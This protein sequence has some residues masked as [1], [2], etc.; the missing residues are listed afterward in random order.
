MVVLSM[1]TNCCRNMRRIVDP[2]EL[3]EALNEPSVLAACAPGF[4]HI[5]VLDLKS[6]LAF[7][8]NG[9]V[10]IFTEREP[11]VFEGHYVCPPSV[12]GLDIKKGCQEVFH[13]LFTTYNARAICGL[14]PRSNRAARVMNRALGFKPVANMSDAAGQDCILYVL[15]RSRWA[16]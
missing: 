11:F 13:E 9:G 6:I 15:E 5:S 1:S 4:E 10:F 2:V 3:E 16:V 12:R 8:A 7:K 14:T